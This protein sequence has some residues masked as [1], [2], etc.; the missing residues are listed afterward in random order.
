MMGDLSNLATDIVSGLRVLRGIGG[1]KVFHD[2]YVARVAEGAQ[3][4]G[5]GGRMQSILDALQILLPGVFVVVVVWVGA[6]FA[7]Q[8]QMTPGELVAFYGYA[9][10]LM[11]PLRTATEFANKG[12]R[13]FVSARRIVRVLSLE[14]EIDQGRGLEAPPADSLL[15]D[16]HERGAA[17]HRD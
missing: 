2:R 13:A 15:V 12:I 3:G 11:M 8:G 9:A 16:P 4:R 5:R 10:F 17:S 7:V 1:E 14:P 6:R